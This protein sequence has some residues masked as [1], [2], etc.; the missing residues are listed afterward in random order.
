MTDEAGCTGRSEC[1]RCG[2]S[3]T[4]ERHDWSDEEV[5]DVEVEERTL[6]KWSESDL[7]TEYTRRTTY[8]KTCR[9]C[10]L[11]ERRT[12]VDSGVV[13]GWG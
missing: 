5:E 6:G 10:S 13:E 4:T 11:V 2:A 7:A 3:R 1:T 9:R 12:E 8:R